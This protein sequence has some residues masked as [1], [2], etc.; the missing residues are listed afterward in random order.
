METSI[1]ISIGVGLFFIILFSIIV[2]ISE[3]TNNKEK[4]CS[5]IE[6]CQEMNSCLYEA[7]PRNGVL[8]E[9]KYTNCLLEKLTKTQK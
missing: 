5:Q 4:A 2:W 3:D 8:H 1:K 7:N 6:D 9:Q